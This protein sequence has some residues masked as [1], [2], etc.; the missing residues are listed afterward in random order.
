MTTTSTTPERAKGDD[1]I[2]VATRTGNSRMVVVDLGK[3]GRKQ[4][5]RLRN[6][7]GRLAEEVQKCISELQS[8]G[9]I[10]A[11]TQPV[12]FVVRQK[13]RRVGLFG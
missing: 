5:K 3:A 10:S 1:K 2:A 13:R 7:E 8:A 11:T 12:V 9:T 6:G 4:V